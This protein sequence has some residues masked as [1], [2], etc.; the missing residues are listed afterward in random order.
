MTDTAKL[1]ERERLRFEGDLDKW[2]KI[3]GAG[4]TGYQPEAYVVMDEACH[5]LVRLRDEIK[6][7]ST[8]Q[9]EADARVKAAVEAER[10]RCAKIADAVEKDAE[11]RYQSH[12]AISDK[13]E[14]GREDAAS[15]IAAAIRSGKSG[16]KQ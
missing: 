12:R 10:E 9:A 15:D 7:L 14:F 4:I 3:I 2:M 13:F 11:D 5:E 8:A 16:A 1:V 6:A